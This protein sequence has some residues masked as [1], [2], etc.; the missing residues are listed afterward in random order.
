MRF[1]PTSA[2]KVEQLKKQAKRLQRTGGG[3]H[4]ELLDR[5]ARGAGYDH[6]HHVIRCLDAAQDLEGLALL[7]REIAAFQK[8]AV[9][10]GRLVR[11]TGSDMLSEPVILFAAEGDAWLL[12]PHSQEC[13]CLAFHGAPIEPV[14]HDKGIQI[15]LQ[16]HGTYRIGDDA[17]HFETGLP[18]VGNRTVLGF[19]LDE[20]RQA[21]MRA[22]ESFEDRFESVVLQADAVPLSPELIDSLLERGFGNFDRRELEQHAKAGARYSPKRDSLL[23]PPVTGGNAGA[24]T[25]PAARSTRPA[26]AVRWEVVGELDRHP[27]SAA[28]L[29]LLAEVRDEYEGMGGKDMVLV[30]EA[31]ARQPIIRAVTRG[32]GAFMA[33]VGGLQDLGLTD[34]LVDAQQPERGVD[35]AF[36]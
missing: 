5:V 6:W 1:I 3:K 21:T 20:L 15:E 17:M 32:L 18:Q 9:E 33:L 11:V 26:D 25:R 2:A 19:P 16:F 36:T 10:G 30:L 8:L 13:M 34:R 7:R 28:V 22:T 29:D 12:D 23:Y 31:S 14:I 4:A 35:A 27:M 24:P